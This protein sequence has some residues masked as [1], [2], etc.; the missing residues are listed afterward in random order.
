M[1]LRHVPRPRLNA[2]LLGLLTLL[3][4]GLPQT[5]AAAVDFR[6]QLGLAGTELRLNW[7]PA[8]NGSAYTVETTTDLADPEWQPLGGRAGWPIAT[9]EWTGPLP[10]PAAKARF[11]RVVSAPVSQRG[12]IVTN[13][14]LKS[15]SLADVTAV[16]AP[17]ALAG[18]PPAPVDAWRVQYATIDPFGAP[19]IASALVVIPKNLTKSLPLISYQHGTSSMR[20]DVPSRLNSEGDLG[21][22]LGAAGYLAVLPDYLGLGDSPGVHPYHHAKSE[23]TAVV[24]AVRAARA[25]FTAQSVPWN[26][27][28]FLTGY[29]HGGHSTLAAQKEIELLHTNE[30]NLVASAPCAGAYDLSG[31]TFTDFLSDRTPPNPYYYGM[32]LTAYSAVYG[33]GTSV[34]DLLRAPYDTTLPPLLDGQHSGGVINAAMPAHPKDILKPEILAALQTDP[35]HPLRQALRDNDLHTGWV[36]RVPTRLYHCSA[37]QDVLVGNSKVAAETFKAAGSTSVEFIDPFALGNHSVC[38]AF[39][40]LGV[41]NWFGTLRQ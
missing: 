7:S 5:F 10:A 26:Q 9:T 24:D 35:N 31:T 27:Q 12:Q 19:T 38:A 6:L 16:L 17:Y 18:I 41:K 34:A 4:L 13:F 1:L 40:L 2:W 3:A 33:V 29:S 37:D 32:L 30:F 11:F 36:P 25:L 28:L 22:V 23:A 39:S 21:V 20:E 14:L 15:Y 8:G